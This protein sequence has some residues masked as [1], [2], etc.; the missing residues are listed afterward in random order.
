[1]NSA[2]L[3]MEPAEYLLVISEDLAGLTRM[4]FFLIS[5]K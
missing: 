5:C 4:I 2:I 1:M 3:K